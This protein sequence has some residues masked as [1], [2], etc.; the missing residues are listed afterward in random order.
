MMTFSNPQ[1]FD[2]K[3]LAIAT[4]TLTSLRILATAPAR[5]AMVEEEPGWPKRASCPFQNPP[6][7][8]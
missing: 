1:L 7:R 3:L 4:S 5:A 8:S 2:F 6:Q